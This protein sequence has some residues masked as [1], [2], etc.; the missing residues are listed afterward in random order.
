MSSEESTAWLISRQKHILQDVDS[1]RGLFK[2]LILSVFSS[3]VKMC[4]LM[5]CMQILAIFWTSFVMFEIPEELIIH[6]AHITQML[7]AIIA[8]NV[9]TS[10]SFFTISLFVIPWIF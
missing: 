5:I 2:Y 10:N 9:F 1:P 4:F 3:C 7:L 6:M 8:V